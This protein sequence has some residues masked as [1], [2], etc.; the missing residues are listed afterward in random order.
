MESIFVMSGAV[1]VPGRLPSTLDALPFPLWA[2]CPA[3]DII[4]SANSFAALG[5]CAFGVDGDEG[6]GYRHDVEIGVGDRRRRIS[7]GDICRF[8]WQA[9][10]PERRLTGRNGLRD[11]HRRLNDA[12]LLR[13][14]LLK[15]CF[16]VVRIFQQR[17]VELTKARR[18]AGEPSTI[19]PENRGSSTSL[20]AFGTAEPFTA[21]VL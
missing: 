18:D 16:A 14:E 21:A 4:Q 11:Q 10:K 7:V 19:L 6:R 3:G 15:K 13:R 5:C 20:H 12:R 17:I 8:V 9:G 1:S 2:T